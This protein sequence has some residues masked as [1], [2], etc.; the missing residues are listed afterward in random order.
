MRFIDTYPEKNE[1][2]GKAKDNPYPKTKDSTTIEN[3]VESKIDMLVPCGTHET[4]QANRALDKNKDC[5]INNK[6]FIQESKKVL[7]DVWN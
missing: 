7:L 6:K 3:N 4:E 5:E 2:S 1:D